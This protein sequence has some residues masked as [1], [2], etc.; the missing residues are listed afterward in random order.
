MAAWRLRPR[1]GP[2]HL[3]LLPSA[4]LVVAACLYLV[5]WTGSLIAGGSDVPSLP[6][7]DLVP[8]V[9]ASP[10]LPVQLAVVA[11]AGAFVTRLDPVV[12]A[13]ALGGVVAG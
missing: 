1:S 13:G 6:W 10:L 9:D 8:G 2:A 5:A 3:A 12:G 11:L 7:G 4:A